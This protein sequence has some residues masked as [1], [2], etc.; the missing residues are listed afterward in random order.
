V[1]D[2][3]HHAAAWVRSPEPR[4]TRP[5]A[6]APKAHPR[7][8]SRQARRAPSGS[9][10]SMSRRSGPSTEIRTW[11]TLHPARDPSLLRE[12]QCLRINITMTTTTR[13]NTIVPPP[14]YMAFPLL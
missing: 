1:V 12:R 9:R 8:C 13:I 14:M 2:V 10:S 7:E 4:T 5:E 6:Q 3:E 11:R